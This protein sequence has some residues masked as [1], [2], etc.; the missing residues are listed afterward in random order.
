MAVDVAVFAILAIIPILLIIAVVLRLVLGLDGADLKTYIVGAVVM[1]VIL[2]AVALPVITNVISDADDTV[3]WQYDDYRVIEGAS[4]ADGSLELV[5]VSGVE[6]VHAKAVGEGTY[7][8]TGEEP[9]SINVSKANLDVFMI[10]GQSNAGYRP[11]SADTSTSAP[12]PAIGTAY[13]YGNADGGVSKPWDADSTATDYE[14]MSAVSEEGVLRL[15]HLEGPFSATYYENTGHKVYTINC[16]IGATNILSWTPGKSSWTWASQ[17]FAAAMDAIDEDLFKPDVKSCIWIQGEADWNQ[18]I[19]Y[20]MSNFTMWMDSIFGES[21]INFSHDYTFEKILIS[22][23][24][25][26]DFNGTPSGINPINPA[27]AQNRLADRYSDVVMVTHIAD[28]FTIANGLM[29]DDNLHYSQLGQNK[30][31]VAMGDYY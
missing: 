24:R 13:Y 27:T 25:V 21:P 23:V 1:V 9:V 22:Q 2:A 20:Y 31:G 4:E 18:S 28:T 29:L 6:Y 8:I 16:A 11:S 10:A 15:A 12:N 19:D 17:V 5:T 14:F 26:I 30:I 3:R 7:T